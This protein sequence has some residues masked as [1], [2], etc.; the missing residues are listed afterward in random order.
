V[1]A[2]KSRLPQTCS[3]AQPPAPSA[4]EC[5][6][7]AQGTLRDQLDRRLLPHLPASSFL[8]PAVA[9]AL[10]HDIAA[11]MLHLHREGIV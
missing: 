1:H 6:S 10:S 11:A 3:H 7:N 4:N 8:H 5:C 2:V 9:V